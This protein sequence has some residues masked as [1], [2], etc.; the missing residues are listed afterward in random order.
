M[1]KT[2]VPTGTEIKGGDINKDGK[3]R[4]SSGSLKKVI[5]NI[6]VNADSTS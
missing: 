6:S 2:V 1:D 5:G 3:K 4:S